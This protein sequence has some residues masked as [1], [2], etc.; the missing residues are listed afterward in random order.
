MKWETEKPIA[1]GE[2][3]EIFCGV[4]YFEECLQDMMAFS[5]LFQVAKFVGN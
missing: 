3:I 4:I 1:S 5:D 2:K